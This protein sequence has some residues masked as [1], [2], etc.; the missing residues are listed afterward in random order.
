MKKILFLVIFFTFKLVFLPSRVIA[1]NS[2]DLIFVSVTDSILE[3]GFG[4]VRASSCYPI[5]DTIKVV[6]SF[7]KKDTFNLFSD[8]QYQKW[9]MIPSPASEKIDSFFVEVIFNKSRILLPVRVVERV[10]KEQNWSKSRT[11]NKASI[12]KIDSV[13][14]LKDLALADT[15]PFIGNFIEPLQGDLVITDE[16]GTKRIFP[17]RVSVHRG[18]DFRASVGTP[19]YATAQGKVMI[20]RFSPHWGNTIMLD[21]QGDFETLY[22]HLSRF[23]VKEGELVDSGELIGYS[24][25]TGH[26]TA[27]HLHY[28][29]RLCKVPVSPDVLVSAS[30]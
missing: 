19:V 25:A 5:E 21:H 22:L 4:F 9:R 12:E 30:N 10:W 18:V 26:V 27:P 3:G 24:G 6:L 1:P 8:D 29:K 13:K 23:A 2:E 16:F 11:K 7:N 17:D 28:T 14:I 15:L 20:A